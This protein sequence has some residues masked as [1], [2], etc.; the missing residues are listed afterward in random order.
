MPDIAHTA[1]DMITGMTPT[2]RDGSFVFG[3]SDDPKVIADLI[4]MAICT[5][6]ENEGTSMIL[7]LDVAQNASF[8]CAA[9]MSCIT[10]NVY[11][12]LEGCGLTAAVATALS[13]N[14]IACN[15]VAAFHHDHAFVPTDHAQE[16]V[17][18]L[19]ELQN[20]QPNS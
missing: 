6:Q 5:F 20:G 19:L 14:G 11:S 15:M 12:S 13:D 3:I 10:L 16:A 7:P 2:L 4:P 9:P 18:V 8:D 17:T 1:N